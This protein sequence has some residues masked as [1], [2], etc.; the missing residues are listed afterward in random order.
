MYPVRRQVGV[1]FWRCIWTMPVSYCCRTSE[2]SAYDVEHGSSEGGRGMGMHHGLFMLLCTGFLF[3]MNSG[4]ARWR[5][6]L[7]MGTVVEL[8]RKKR[9]PRISTR[10][11]L[12]VK[13]GQ[14]DAGRDGRACLVRPNFYTRT[15]TGKIITSCS[16]DQSSIGNQIRLMRRLLNVMTNSINNK[17]R[18][19]KY[20]ESNNLTVLLV[21]G[22]TG[23]DDLSLQRIWKDLTKKSWP[24]SQGLHDA[25]TIPA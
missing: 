14:A 21:Y 2:V 5:S 18:A 20:R 16:A 4:L 3:S 13:N 23:Y 22:V 10:F 19:D 24:A 9:S 11:S 15:G 6:T 25:F 7:S 1:V 8:G 12:G 17:K